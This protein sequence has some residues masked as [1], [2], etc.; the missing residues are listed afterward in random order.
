MNVGIATEAA[1]FL[2]WE[3]L[4]RIFGIVS[5]QCGVVGKFTAGII[6]MSQCDDHRCPRQ[7]QLICPQC[8]QDQV[9]HWPPVSFF[10]QWCTL[11]CDY[12][13]EFLNKIILASEGKMIQE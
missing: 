12:L 8:Q 7:Q 4:F 5:L 11:S 9:A 3:Y 1:Q 13:R 10:H 6:E 2:F